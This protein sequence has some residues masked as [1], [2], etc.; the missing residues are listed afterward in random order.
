MLLEAESERLG[1]LAYITRMPFYFLPQPHDI[2]EGEFSIV[3][4]DRANVAAH[5]VI[6]PAKS[7]IELRLVFLSGNKVVILEG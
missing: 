7:D 1:P 2:F 4:A 3:I 6:F 5:E